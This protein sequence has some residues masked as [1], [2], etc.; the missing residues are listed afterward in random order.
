MCISA[1]IA[2]RKNKKPINDAR[3]IQI[4][5]YFSY[6]ENEMVKMWNSTGYIIC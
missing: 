6:I 1:L 2:V 5:I 3:N 4:I